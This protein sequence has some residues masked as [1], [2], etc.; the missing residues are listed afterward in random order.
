MNTIRANALPLIL[1]ALLI[2]GVTGASGA[3]LA[4][5]AQD[6]SNGAQLTAPAATPAPRDE[7]KT[8]Y[9]IG[10]YD[11][12]MFFA[13]NAAGESE[14]A[15]SDSCL[16]FVYTVSRASWYEASDE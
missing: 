16:G 15:A 12:C 4:R 3:L 8:A 13:V 10:V 7:P 1:A 9:Y 2:G 11:T 14:Q 6:V 5:Y